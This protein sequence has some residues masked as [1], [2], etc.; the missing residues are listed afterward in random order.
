MGQ[1]FILFLGNIEY[2]NLPIN[3]TNKTESDLAG[4]N[5]SLIYVWVY[6]N[7]KKQNQE[8]SGFNVLEGFHIY[9]L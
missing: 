5:I 7:K 9:S 8:A 3:Y 4:C 1:Y 6:L 2:F